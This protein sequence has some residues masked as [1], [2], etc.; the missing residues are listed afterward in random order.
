M[1]DSLLGGLLLVL[2][3]KAF[4][5]LI[6]GAFIGYWVGILPGIGGYCFVEQ[7]LN[8]ILD[9]SRATVTPYCRIVCLGC[10]STQLSRY[11]PDYLSDCERKTLRRRDGF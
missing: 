8:V 4:L 7:Q 3:W 2:Q 10:R 6:I 9:F 11:G 1:F 5:Y